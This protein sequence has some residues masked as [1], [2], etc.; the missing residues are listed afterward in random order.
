MHDHS[1]IRP[2]L[3]GY[4]FRFRQRLPKRSGAISA[5]TAFV[6]TLL[7]IMMSDPAH[8]ADPAIKDVFS[9]QSFSEEWAIGGAV[10][11]YDRDTLFNHIDGE[12]EL[13]L[14]YGFDVLASAN[15]ISKKNLDLS[16]VAD[17]YRM[18]SLLDAFGI[19]SNYRKTSNMWVAIGAEGFVSP[20][21]LM[22]YQDRYFIRLQVSGETSLPENILLA[23]ARTVSKNL[24][25]GTG[26]PKELDILNIPALVPKSE[27]YLA[28]SLL[29]YAFFRKGMIAD[30]VAQDEK[31][32]IFALHEDTQADASKT[33][34]QYYAYLKSETKSIQLTG[35]ANQRLL[36]AVDPLYGGVL[37]RQSGR[38]IIGAVRVKNNSLARQFI[39]QMHKRIGSDA[40]T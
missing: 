19:Y 8:A 26:Q 3:A 29:G 1:N 23:C 32:Q 34:D 4:P 28:Q 6:L 16:I 40:G 18:A 12:A 20:S 5:I 7:I 22:F 39:A 30:A 15:Y 36:V 13:Y 9:G 38:Y 25:A 35:N 24:P 10:E 37:A 21:Q 31:M 14:P 17:V 11:F 33:F 27:R 2:S